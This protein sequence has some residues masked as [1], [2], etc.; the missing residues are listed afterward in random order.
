MSYIVSVATLT[1]ILLIGVLGTYLVTGQTGLF[2]MGQGA[3]L[4]IGAYASAILKMRFGVPALPAAIVAIILAGLIA[5]LIGFATLRLSQ[6]YFA[7][8]TFGFG[9]ALIATLNLAVGLT[10]GSRGLFGIPK[11]VEPWMVITVLIGIIIFVS[12]LKQH[13]FGRRCKAIRDNQLTAEILGI[14]AFRHKMKVYI[15]GA[16]ITATAG[17]FYGFYISYVDP[18]MFGWMRSAEWVIIV[19]FGGRNS[20]TGSLLSGAVLLS[21][22]EILRFA[23]EWRT[24]IYCVLVILIISFRPEGVMGNHEF[25]IWRIIKRVFKKD[26]KRSLPDVGKE[27]E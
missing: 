11:L 27:V 24:I 23:N 10:G 8:A 20:L 7:L 6:D 9:E 2:S 3:F 19:F 15:L 4:A 17:A 26:N 16:V 5:A 21:L 18:S 25:N 1:S 14:N 12:Y 22:P 13:D